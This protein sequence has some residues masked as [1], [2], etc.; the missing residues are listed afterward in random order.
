MQIEQFS[1]VGVIADSPGSGKTYVVLSLIMMDL[2]SVNV[3]VVPQNIYTQWDEAIKVFCGENVS[4]TKFITY[5]EVS[6]LYFNPS[7]LNSNIILTTPLYYNVIMDA[8]HQKRKV[9]RVFVDEIDSVVS[10]LTKKKDVCNIVWFVSASVTPSNLSIMGYDSRPFEIISCRCEEEFIKQSFNIP[11][12]DY[13]KVIC[14]NVLIDHVL[15]GLITDSEY[16][17]INAMDFN[18]INKLNNVMV[19]KNEK[20]A[21][22]YFIKDLVDSKILS[23][24]SIKDLEK[25]LENN[26][27]MNGEDKCKIELALKDKKQYLQN[28][29]EKIECLKERLEESNICSICYCDIKSRVI[30]VC[31]KNSY[32]DTCLSVW[33]DKSPDKSC[34]TCRDKNVKVV[35]MF[36]DDNSSI[37]VN[38]SQTEI[39]TQTESQKSKMEELQYLLINSMG[40]KVIIFADYT[41]I[42]KE[43][44]KML[45]R[46]NIKYVELDGGN[47]TS[48]DR[49]ISNYKNGEVRVL[50][51]NSSLYGCGMNL[52]NTSDIV[53]LHKTNI[54]MKEQ[55]IGRA[56]RPGR[57]S[58]LNVWELL[59]E[60]EINASE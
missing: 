15:H 5:H 3:I 42:F 40:D 52:Q 48:I 24:T 38:E 20:E 7:I 10:L 44:S 26:T 54:S 59:H 57:T 36:E 25:T 58:R 45:E 4:Y 60:N 49:D 13:H 12:P 14:H 28:I 41:S 22:D 18:G 8:L 47:I 21:V 51:T 55:V 19:A 56:Q 23:I 2:N 34:P 30:T 31:C 17:R 39:Q 16:S 50:M 1:E 53:L 29:E 32:C 46:E 6:A 11:E 33:M 43:I 37:I 35:S 27:I 9:S